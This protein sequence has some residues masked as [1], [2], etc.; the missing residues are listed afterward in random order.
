MDFC[1]R[2]SGF[3]RHRLFASAGCAFLLGCSIAQGAERPDIICEAPGEP[4]TFDGLMFSPD[5]R[6]VLTLDNT[7]RVWRIAD[8]NLVQ[9][10]V[11]LSGRSGPDAGIFTID[12][13]NVI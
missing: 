3:S 1:Y 6:Q 4:G 10:F 12:G 7:S 9:T 2:L 13:A 5:S 11:I 8:T